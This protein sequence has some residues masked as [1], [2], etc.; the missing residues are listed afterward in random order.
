MSCVD[1][2]EIPGKHALSNIQKTLLL[3]SSQPL[4]VKVEKKRKRTKHVEERKMSLKVDKCKET[5]YYFSNN[6]R[7]VHPYTFTFCASMKKRWIGMSVM[8]LYTNEFRGE[9]EEYYKVAVESGKIKVNGETVNK[10]YQLQPKDVIENTS[11]R[12]EP[13]VL[14]QDIPIICDEEGMVVVDKPPSI[15]VHPTGRYRH[16]SIVFILEREHGHTGLHA[17][18]NLDRLASGLLIFAK[19]ESVEKDMSMEL[20]CGVEREIVVRVVGEFPEDEVVVEQP[21]ATVSQHLALCHVQDGGDKCS[22]TF[23]R[24]SYNGV[25]SVVSCKVSTY[26]LHQV[27]VHLRWL[28]HPIVNDPIYN[29][30][31][32]WGSGERKN[33]MKDVIEHLERERKDKGEGNVVSDAKRRKVEDDS[34]VVYTTSDI[35]DEYVDKD[36]NDCKKTWKQPFPSE[37]LMYYHALSYKGRNWEYKTPTIPE[38]AKDDWITD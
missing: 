9:S 19:N 2:E 30:P 21:V 16:N 26:R 20:R 1:T 35:G 8:Q 12:H 29:H 3:R 32:A 27:R 31:T 36:C 10:E 25:S 11:H 7:W 38:W 4:Q 15:P 28:G 14:H 17:L 34:P 37:L 6:L 33:Q 22:T 18:H 13:P 23:K 24:L 5:S